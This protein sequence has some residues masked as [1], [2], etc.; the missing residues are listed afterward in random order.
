MHANDNA[1][2]VAIIY[3]DCYNY[4]G[5]DTPVTER[6]D[7]QVL[8]MDVSVAQSIQSEHAYPLATGGGGETLLDLIHAHLSHAP[9]QCALVRAGARLTVLPRPSRP[10]LPSVVLDIAAEEEG[11]CGAR[12]VSLPHRHPV[13]SL[14]L[15][16]PGDL[17]LV[18]NMVAEAGA[19]YTSCRGL[20]LDPREVEQLDSWQ[21][22][23]GDLKQLL[24]ES[25]EGQLGLRSRHCSFVLDQ[26][27]VRA[28]VGAECGACQL[29]ATSLRAKYLVTAGLEVKEEASARKRGRPRGSKNKA[30][31]SV[32]IPEIDTELVIDSK[33][34]KTDHVDVAVDYG[35]DR[36]DDTEHTEGDDF[37]TDIHNSDEDAELNKPDDEAVEESLVTCDD[38]R[39]RGDSKY[40][41]FCGYEDCD[42]QFDSQ[43]EYKLHLQQHAGEGA[44]IC[45]ILDCNKV[46]FSQED[47]DTHVQS[48]SQVGFSCNTCT[49]SFTSKADLKTHQKTHSGW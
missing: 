14:Q 43:Y 24:I 15:T 47:L 38:K 2:N 18:S 41:L 20:G 23:A 42:K 45:N 17:P 6:E 12:L 1:L 32:P 34:M 5:I 49:K 39:P 16:C 22:E 3:Y 40:E 44:V 7:D 10:G 25:Y 11:G 35:H 28:G 33:L 48:H 31:D 19:R 37:Y 29:L 21:L 30:K 13:T 36:N 27:E 4:I 46:F 8:T 9:A 26:E